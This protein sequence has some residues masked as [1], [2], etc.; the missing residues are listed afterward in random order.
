MS[1]VSSDHMFHIVEHVSDHN[2]FE[3]SYIWN[4]YNKQ[5]APCVGMS[6]VM[7]FLPMSSTEHQNF[8]QLSYGENLKMKLYL[9]HSNV[10]IVY[11]PKS[12]NK[13]RVILDQGV[14]MM[15]LDP[16]LEG[17]L[18]VKG[19]ELS[20]KKVHMA[21]TGVFKVTDLA[22]FPVANY[23]VEVKGEKQDLI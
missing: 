11:K 12:D 5:M 19:S 6:H 7:M 14:L 2:Q 4:G 22:G 1:E 23:Y 10:N 21:D 18:T 9:H 3:K 13:D 16:L 20:V 8:M 17:R 15:P